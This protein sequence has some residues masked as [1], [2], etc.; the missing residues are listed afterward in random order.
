MRVQ[1]TKCRGDHV[2]LMRRHPTLRILQEVEA[3]LLQ[4]DEIGG[5]I[6]HPTV[7]ILMRMESGLSD[8]VLIQLGE[9]FAVRKSEGELLRR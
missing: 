7:E 5:Q 9:Q 1:F 3:A 2:T 8:V 4:I 6:S